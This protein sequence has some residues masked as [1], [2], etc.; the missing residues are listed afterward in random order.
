MKKLWFLSGLLAVIGI[1]ACHN[2]PGIVKDDLRGSFISFGFKCTSIADYSASEVSKMGS[3]III[4]RGASEAGG[5]EWVLDGIKRYTSVHTCYYR[6]NETDS[7]KVLS[8]QSSL[9]HYNHFNWGW[10]TFGVGWFN[11]NVFSSSYY[12]SLDPSST[13]YNGGDFKNEVKFIIV[14]K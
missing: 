13:P 7:W 11:D 8:R 10:G 3:N 4:M 12:H 9:C 1:C 5:H 14:S 6:E 2:E